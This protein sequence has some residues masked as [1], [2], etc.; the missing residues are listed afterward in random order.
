MEV[1]KNAQ[2]SIWDIVKVCHCYVKELKY[3]GFSSD[4]FV[5]KHIF[6][7]FDIFFFRLF[8]RRHYPTSAVTF[9]GMDPKD[10]RWTQSDGDKAIT[11]DACVF[12]FI[13]RK[14]GSS[15]HNACH[16]F[17]ETDPEQ[18]AS[19]IVN[20]INRVLLGLET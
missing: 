1:D 4:K 15:T 3:H 2:F 17:A 11:K 12:G 5:L 9:C 14:P 10:Q 13:A 7:H 18:P 16:L 20:F 8:F 6:N 19:A